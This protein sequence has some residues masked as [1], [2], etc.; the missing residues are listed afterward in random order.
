MRPGARLITHAPHSLLKSKNQ[1]SHYNGTLQWHPAMAP[2]PLN[3]SWS[4]PSA[5]P[6][7]TT[8]APCNGT[9]S[10][11]PCYGILVPRPMRKSGSSPSPPIGSKNPY[12][13]GY[14]GKKH[15]ANHFVL[16][17]RGSVKTCRHLWAI[18]CAPPMLA[19]LWSMIQIFLAQVVFVCVCVAPSGGKITSSPCT[20]SGQFIIK[21]LTWIFRPFWVPDSR[22]CHYL[23]GVTN[24][25]ERSR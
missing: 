17:N 10:T 8:M 20:W 5:Q 22:T 6:Y 7:H 23:L 16:D 21:S 24:R 19:S 3:Q 14:L 2:R 13:Y 11:A 9:T 1:P 4:S 12:S 15:L 25:R 18:L